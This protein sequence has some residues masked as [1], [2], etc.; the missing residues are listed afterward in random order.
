[1]LALQTAWWAIGR[2]CLA[3]SSHQEKYPFFRRFRHVGKAAGWE[4]AVM[5]YRLVC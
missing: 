5:R 4:E 1:M 3:G 2:A